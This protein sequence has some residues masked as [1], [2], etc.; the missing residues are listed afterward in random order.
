MLNWS[1]RFNIFSFLDTHGYEQP[2]SAQSC[3][4]GAGEYASFSCAAGQAFER[5]QE[6]SQ[7]HKDWL[8]GHLSYDLK[9]ETEKLRSAHPDG[10]GFDDLRFFVPEVVLQLSAKE[11]VIGVIGTKPNEI[12]EQIN[13]A[14]V[15]T[16]KQAGNLDIH[17][18]FSREE[19]IDAVNK[20][21]AHILRGDCYE[22]N[23]CQ[24]FYSETKE[25]NPIHTSAQLSVTSPNPFAA[26]Y[27][28]EHRYLVCASPERYLC[29][30]GQKIF[31]Q[32]IKGTAPRDLN[33][34]EKDIQIRE[35]L[36]KNTKERA[37]NVMVVDLVRND[38]SRV[39]EEGSVMVDELC[40][41]YSFPQVHQMISTISGVLPENTS[42]V[43]V[44]KQ[45]FPMGSMTGAPKRKVLE[46]IEQYE[47]TR[48]GLFSGAV[49]YFHPNGNF[50]FN[51][52]IRSLFY[53]SHSGYLSFQVGS[54]ITFYAD[55]ASEYEECLLKVAAIKKVLTGKDQ[56]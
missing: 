13:S 5:L 43:E 15:N 30:R 7:L 44:L 34:P 56:H 32:P 53:N 50:D 42:S 47:K 48:R 33:D 4:L 3:L 12:W 19:Y 54:G 51:V 37:E 23:F 40:E 27:K 28:N 35:E 24:E 55:A 11:L 17:S 2:L 29:K 21:K 38:L 14:D 39:C 52:V 26:L 31:S 25:F 1:D 36:K 22:L 49:G 46:L 16:T 10:I 8:F 6:F 41:V 9:N 20:I 45:S 18:R